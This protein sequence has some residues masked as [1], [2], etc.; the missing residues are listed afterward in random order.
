MK[1]QLY[2]CK[3]LRKL[4]KDE[5][6]L[7]KNTFKDRILPSFENIE[8]EAEDVQNDFYNNV[9]HSPCDDPDAIDPASIAESAL[10]LGI[11]YYEKISLMKYNTLAMWISMLYQYWEQQVRKFLYDEERHYFELEFKT[12]CSRGIR[13]IK[14]EFLFHKV[15][16]EE[17]ICWEKIDELRLL[18]NSLK[19]GDGN[20]AQELK[21]RRPDLFVREELGNIDLLKLY[22]ATLLEVVLNIDEKSFYKYCD[23]LMSFWDELPERMYED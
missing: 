1:S 5:I 11:D 9:M 17:L 2:L 13:D 21:K 8:K 15:N 6:K 20:S 12:F 18:C 14:E 10:E 23:V 3:G 7:F 22:K 19:H 16:I 4:K